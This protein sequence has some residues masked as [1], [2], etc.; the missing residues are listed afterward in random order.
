M[1]IFVP[2][3]GHMQLTRSAHSNNSDCDRK[4]TDSSYLSLLSVQGCAPG[5]HR[6][7]AERVCLLRTVAAHRQRIKCESERRNNELDHTHG[8]VLALHYLLMNNRPLCILYHPTNDHSQTWS[9]QWK[10]SVHICFKHTH[11][12]TH[13][14]HTHTHTHAPRT[15]ARTHAR[16]HTTHAR[17]HET[18]TDTLTLTHTRHAHTFAHT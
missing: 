17:T 18:L 13:D 8:P 14:V 4:E 6:D 3:A 10:L 12:H 11:A 16:T 7:K 2:T 1:K 5:Q 15:H 9:D